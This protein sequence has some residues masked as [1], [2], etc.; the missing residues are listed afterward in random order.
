MFVMLARQTSAKAKEIIELTE[1]GR[2]DFLSV[3]ED[4]RR[5]PARLMS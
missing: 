2:G 4:G 5:L 1:H 3:P